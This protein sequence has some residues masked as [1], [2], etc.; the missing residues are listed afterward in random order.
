[1]CCPCQLLVCLRASCLLLRCFSPCCFLKSRPTF[2]SSD[3]N[4]SALFCILFTI[5]AFMVKSY[6]RQSSFLK[7]SLISIR[8]KVYIHAETSTPSLEPL[9]SLSGFKLAGFLAQTWLLVRL[10]LWRDHCRNIMITCF[11]HHKT[12]FDVCLVS[13]SWLNIQLCSSCNH[14]AVDLR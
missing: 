1:M 5:C 12:S 10:G 11:I 9:A 4:T 8:S 3:N 14:L 6:A 2:D 13:L 7:F